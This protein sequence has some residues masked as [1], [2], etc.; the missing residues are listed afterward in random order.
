[1]SERQETVIV[2]GGQAGL[3]MSHHLSRLGRAHVI[4]ERSRVAERWR[5]ERWDSL[6][7]QFPNWSMRLP[8]QAYDG[9]DPDGFATRDEVI[10]FIE[11]YRE[12]IRAPVRTG[13]DVTA[14]RRST[15]D[16]LDLETTHGLIEAANVVVAT[17]PY[18]EP[19]VPAMSRALPGR[20]RQVHSSGYRNPGQLP[21]GAV[22]VVGSGA[23]GCQIVED[24]LAAERRVYLSVGRHRRF[25]RRYR[26]HDMFWWMERLGVLDHPL[27][28]RPEARERPNPLVTGVG[29]GHEID[30]RRYRDDGVVLLGHLAGVTGSRL[31]LADDVEA[32]LAAGDESVLA[33]TR[34]VDA[35]VDRSG[36]VAPAE[37]S[38]APPASSETSPIRELDL[39]GAGIAAVIWA[40]GFRRDFGWIR[41]PVL[42]DGG[43]PVHRRGVTRCPGVYFLGLPWLHTLRS[44]VLCGVGDDA[45]H[46]A[47]HIASRVPAPAARRA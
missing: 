20:V 47:E 18:Q 32:L 26:G 36:L 21:A 39:D 33:F 40:T 42:D 27:E 34:A 30:L 44:S 14:L 7:F 1:M 38:P 3:A 41:L 5:S 25:P 19:V 4:L 15:N 6:M 45:A 37:P 11:R 2:G 29:G 23:S 16:A 9:G 10:A 24:L 12:V 31:H 22:L 43:E 28:E 13:V 35:Y 8:G 46:L 17:G